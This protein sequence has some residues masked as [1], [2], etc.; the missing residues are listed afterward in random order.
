MPHTAHHSYSAQKCH[1]STKKVPM[2]AN[3]K[4]YV[5]T[6]TEV[7]V[8]GLVGLGAGNGRMGNRGTGVEIHRR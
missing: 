4:V 5:G 6:S 7:D 8:Y 1:I 2:V 3:G